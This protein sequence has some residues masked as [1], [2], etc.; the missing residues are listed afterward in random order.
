[1]AEDRGDGELEQKLQ[2]WVSSAEIPLPAE[3]QQRVG[4]RLKASLK[5]VNPLPPNRAL[6]SQFLLVFVSLAAALIAA[7]EKAG[8]RLMT[9]GQIGAM[10]ALLAGGGVYFAAQLP[11]RMVPGS[12][13]AA[14]WARGLALRLAGGGAAMAL[15]FPWKVPAAFAAEGWPCAV[16]EVAVARPATAVFFLMAQRG[17]LFASAGL[18]ATLPA[19]AVFLALIADQAQCMFPQA[20]HLLVWHGGTAAILIA[21]GAMVGRAMERRQR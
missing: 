14:P 17:A 9:A 7:L 16:L 2:E 11:K 1:M 12:R 15:L 3:V 5:P 10:G 6:A 18:G 20:P 19:L 21:T 4:S 13:V 8:F